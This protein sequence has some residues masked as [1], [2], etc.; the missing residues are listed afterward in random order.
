MSSEGYQAPMA[1]GG[2][3]GQTD[4]PNLNPF[5]S[6]SNID[7]QQVKADAN[8]S[9]QNV[10]NTVYDS[11]HLSARSFSL[12][13]SHIYTDAQAAMDK[14]ANHPMTQNIANG[15]CQRGPVAQKGR[16]EFGK[17]QN[18][19]SNLVN[20]R[21]IPD[22]KTATGQELTQYHSMFYNLLSWQ[23][24][25]ATTISY[26]TMVVFI[27]FTRYVP[28]L[29]YIFKGLYVV[30]GITAAAEIAGRLVFENGLASQMR[31]R[32]YYTI[33][34]QSLENALE[35]VEQLINFFVIEFQRIVFA[36]NIYATIAAF[37]I[38]LFG[39][40][41]VK[42]VPKWGLALITVT[43]NLSHAGEIL[44]QQTQQA[45]E[46]SAQYTNRAVEVTKSTAN[47]YTAKAQ[48][49]IGQAK[50]RASSPSAPN[51][52]NTNPYKNE[53]ERNIENQASRSDAP[54]PANL[55]PYK[56]EPERNVEN[57]ASSSGAP[58]PANL[59][60]YKNEPERNIDNQDFP[61]AP[62]NEPSG[63]DSVQARYG[64]AEPVLE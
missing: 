55:N 33:P 27:F 39:Y 53:P 62:S 46:L 52:A 56:N 32:K 37:T 5:A 50:N 43:G 54:N 18:E 29:K 1:N 30:L 16:E 22:Q 42:F 4:Y 2:Q 31:P 47:T 12:H 63:P 38:A 6:N 24:P 36:E 11:E 58:N 64:R 13:P 8:G 26:A 3:Q 59:N 21:Q 35:D 23:N 60:P 49:M 57:Q 28:V 51:P 7:T 61:S 44:N 40:F 19:F 10:K 15:S 9:Y 45:R 20:S 34:R 17:T 48:E 14:V 41:A 25:R